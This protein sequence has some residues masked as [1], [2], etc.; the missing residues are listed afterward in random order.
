MWEFEVHF[1]IVTQAVKMIASKEHNQFDNLGI[2]FLWNLWFHSLF[3][4]FLSYSRITIII[5]LRFV[6]IKQQH[7]HTHTLRSVK[8]LAPKINQ[9]S[10]KI[11]SEHKEGRNWS[12]LKSIAKKKNIVKN[13]NTGLKIAHFGWKHSNYLCNSPKL[14]R[15]IN[16]FSRSY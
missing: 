11:K 8:N 6:R 1:D 16:F 3:E 14:K 7:R 9:M 5:V 4:I 2:N 12:R 10:L 15:N 13:E